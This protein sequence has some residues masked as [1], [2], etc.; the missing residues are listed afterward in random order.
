MNRSRYVMIAAASAALL[1]AGRLYAQTQP[2]EPAPAAAAPAAPAATPPLEELAWLRGCWTGKVDRYDFIEQW[3]PPRA[4]MMIG[5]SHTT[6]QDKQHAAAARTDDYS[7]LR[8]EARADG[9]YYVAIPSGKKEAAF[10]LTSARE[11]SGRM[12]Y[13]FTN[14]ADEFPQRI[15]MCEARGWLYAQVAG[16]R[17]E[18]KEITSDAARRLRN[19]RVRPTESPTERLGVVTSET[20]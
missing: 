12:L 7:Y 15:A 3:S 8:L 2:P 1:L 6:V 11:E 9:I 5:F 14:P 19:R 16:C 17:S 20:R 13:T 4:G 10:K 18:Q